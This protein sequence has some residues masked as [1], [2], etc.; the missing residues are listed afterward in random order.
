MRREGLRRKVSDNLS[1]LPAGAYPYRK[2]FFLTGCL[3]PDKLIIRNIRRKVLLYGKQK[4][5]EKTRSRLWKLLFVIP[6][7]KAVNFKGMLSR[8]RN[9]GA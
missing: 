3:R 7:S 9:P 2:S 6:E 8:V 5:L 4:L 1:L